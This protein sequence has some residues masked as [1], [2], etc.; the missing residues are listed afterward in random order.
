M[1]WEQRDFTLVGDKAGYDLLWVP[2]AHSVGSLSHDGDVVLI[3]IVQ[4][5]IEDVAARQFSSR[6]GPGSP[7]GF[8]KSIPALQ[9]ISISIRDEALGS[10]GEGHSPV[11]PEERYR[12]TAV[13][14]N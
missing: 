7:F 10:F 4:L 9:K 14:D 13:L 11:N 6:K 2:A 5:R 8:P 3:S 1:L 12:G